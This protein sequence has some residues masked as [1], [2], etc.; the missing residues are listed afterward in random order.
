MS[1]KTFIVTIFLLGASFSL[2]AER[3]RSYQLE[4]MDAIEEIQKQEL[5]ERSSDY[6]TLLSVKYNLLKGKVDHAE[7]VLDRINITDTKMKE[8]I[9]RYKA[10]TSFINNDFIETEKMLDKLGSAGAEYYKNI[11]TLEL[12]VN[13]VLRKKKK[14]IERNF[15][16]CKGAL[17]YDSPDQLFF[18]EAISYYSRG[19]TLSL[20]KH[21]SKKVQYVIQ[22][23]K[24]IE[25]WMKAAIYTGYPDIIQRNLKYVPDSAFSSKTIR[26]LIGFV[27]YKL[28]MKEDMKL[29][30]ED[31]H[32]PNSENIKAN[33]Y[34]QQEQYELALGHL[35]LAIKQKPNS[36]NSIER[37]IPVTILLNKW[38]KGLEISQKLTQ[39]NM[40]INMIKL[41][42]AL[43]LT[44]KNELKQSYRFLHDIYRY[45]TKLIPLSA[46]QLITYN[47]IRLNDHEFIDLFVPK[48]CTKFDGIAC[49]YYMQ[50]EIWGRLDKTIVRDE[51]IA[52]LDEFSIDDLKEK[53]EIKPLQEI[54]NID[55]K[56]I[57]ELDGVF[58]SEVISKEETS[59]E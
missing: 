37:G 29:F 8:V 54:V 18:L 7:T 5:R 4:H 44:E 24:T 3:P 6:N 22:S 20:V 23:D 35:L 46:L 11:C 34:L 25:A 17:F 42:K 50:K 43:F 31:L 15:Q 58:L 51:K 36:M 19:D 48:S 21:L 14:Y 40:P 45:Y 27:Y 12:M 39:K 53:Q 26:E 38:S 47:A 57:D 49:W 32:T 10:L 16:S 41:L 52:I 2:F 1:M 59:S 13:I 55:Q 28:D 9:Y 33:L 30:L 56:D